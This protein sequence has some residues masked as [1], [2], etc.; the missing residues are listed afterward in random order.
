MKFMNSSI[1]AP[2]LILSI[3]MLSPLFAQQKY[4]LQQQLSGTWYNPNSNRYLRFDISSNHSDQVVIS[5]WTGR[6][7]KDRDK[8]IDVYRAHVKESKLIMYA[9]KEQHRCPYCEITLQD[10]KLLYE[11]NSG[12]NFTDNFLN[13]TVGTSR[14]VFKKLK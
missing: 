2:A 10:K 11:C 6:S 4:T 7:D 8:S 1:K 9:E 5:D 12:L 3:L 13:H 14:E